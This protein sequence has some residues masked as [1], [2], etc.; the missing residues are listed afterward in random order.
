MFRSKT[1]RDKYYQANDNAKAEGDRASDKA[2]YQPKIIGV[3]AEY[4][5]G[6]LWIGIWQQMAGPG[7]LQFSQ[8]ICC[9]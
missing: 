6:V 7:I 3:I 1:C 4:C 5:V 2:N 8:S 9:T